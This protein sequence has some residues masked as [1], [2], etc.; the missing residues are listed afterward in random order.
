M[1]HVERN[2]QTNAIVSD[3][4]IFVRIKKLFSE[5][6]ISKLFC[7]LFIFFA[8]PLFYYSLGGTYGNEGDFA[9]SGTMNSEIPVFC[10]DSIYK[11]VLLLVAAL[12]VL[13]MVAVKLPGRMSKFFD[14][15]HRMDVIAGMAGVLVAIVG[16][17]W[18]NMSGHVP[19]GDQFFVY[20]SAG[21][22]N[23]GDFSALSKGGYIGIYRQQLGLLTFQRFL[24]F[25]FGENNYKIFQ[26]F[27]SIM[28]GCFV[29][30]SY[31]ITRILS[32]SSR[33]AGLC[34]LT[35]CLFCVPMYIYVPYVYGEI[36]STAMV[37]LAAW[38]ILES[39][40]KISIVKFIILAVSG[41]FAIW[42]RT[43]VIIFIIGFFI[44][45]AVKLLSAR[46]KQAIIIMTS[47]TVGII[48]F[49]G[50]LQIL[51]RDKIPEDSV[52]MP[53][54]LHIAMGANEDN[55][56][57][58][59]YNGYNYNTYVDNDCDPTRASAAAEETLKE[60][61]GK[62]REDHDYTVDFFSRKF[63]SQWNAP[64]YQCIPMTQY[65]EMERGRIAKSI[66][67]GSLRRL[68]QSFM[69][70]HQLLVYGALLLIPFVYRKKSGHIEQY[71]TLIGIYGGFLFS[72]LWEAKSRY[73]LPYFMMMMPYA[74]LGVHYL[75]YTLRQFWTKQHR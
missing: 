60:F 4:K 46:K 49:Q 61:I 67:T 3:R 35:L 48:F 71:I 23:A 27:S 16:S 54:I 47:L 70:I 11:N 18:I 26:Y 62:C 8:L 20:R 72:L 30:F 5:Q 10:Y 17:V 44:C 34:C 63:Y 51:Y 12:L 1:Q 66:Y 42:L 36:S 50:I 69:N 13:Y 40:N 7:C 39:F 56:A 52:P 28:A 21:A 14:K 2:R 57:P 24:Y 58:G 65:A 19:I 59:W 22:F 37:A 73:C 9:Q 74:S 32:N 43:N 38:M 6:F 53:A 33:T 68:L 41:G 31:R 29:F 75:F 45:C 15:K 55:F 64:M 25:V